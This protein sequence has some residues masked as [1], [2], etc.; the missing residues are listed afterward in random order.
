MITSAHPPRAL[1]VDNVLEISLVLSS[2]EYV[3]ANAYQNTDLFWALRGGGGGTYGIVT[4]VT[5]LTYPDV[6]VQVYSFQATTPNP[7]VQH[8]FV[9]GFLQ[10]QGRL[11]GAGWG[12]Y[13]AVSSNGL[14]FTYY[15]PGMANDT[16]A[17]S[18]QDWQN[19]VDLMAFYGIQSQ[20]QTSY[21]PS[22]YDVVQDMMY[23]G[24]QDDV[25]GYSLVTSQLI[26]QETPIG[27]N[28]SQIADL[29][30]NCTA[31]FKYVWICVHAGWG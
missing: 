13:G 10:Y 15:A 23:S 5:Y 19:W 28:I 26:S 31:G 12:G 2:G 8:T 25:G 6:P 24:G 7:T 17:T 29:L 21:Y 1:G 20:Y 22:W 18:I 9:I 16:V 11:A 14:N 3:V 4:S 30:I 27:N